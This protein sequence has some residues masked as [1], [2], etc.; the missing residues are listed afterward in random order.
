MFEVKI[1]ECEV[2]CGL[3]FIKGNFISNI[4]KRIFIFLLEQGLV[5]S[6]S[7]AYFISFVA[8]IYQTFCITSAMHVK[9]LEPLQ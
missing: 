4:S 2:D 3:T 7:S 5:V 1:R 9:Q 6:L 8:V